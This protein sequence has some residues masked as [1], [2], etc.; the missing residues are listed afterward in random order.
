MRQA[1]HYWHEDEKLSL[2]SRHWKCQMCSWHA[3]DSVLHLS[4]LSENFIKVKHLLYFYINQ[5]LKKVCHHGFFCQINFSFKNKLI[6]QW[7]KFLAKEASVHRTDLHPMPVAAVLL[8][9]ARCGI[10]PVA[11]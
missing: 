11:V 10:S 5:T 2:C 6:H 9:P 7:S 4:H 8:W 3:I 1:Q